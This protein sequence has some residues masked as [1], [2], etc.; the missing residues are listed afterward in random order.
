MPSLLEAG[1][2]TPG[3]GPLQLPAAALSQQVFA[4]WSGSNDF[5]LSEASTQAA[6]WHRAAGP[7]M[8]GVDIAL[9]LYLSRQSCSSFKPHCLTVSRFP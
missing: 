1:I 4:W 5:S 3:N 2:R 8:I 7:Q 9:T 6:A